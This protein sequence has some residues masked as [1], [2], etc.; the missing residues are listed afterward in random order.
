MSATEAAR[1]GEMGGARS[2]FARLRVWNEAAFDY[3]DIVDC[4]K[5]RDAREEYAALHRPPLIYVVSVRWI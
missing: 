3:A 4:A 2:T 5:G 1:Q